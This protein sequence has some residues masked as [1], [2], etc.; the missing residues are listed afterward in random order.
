V[1]PRVIVEADAFRDA[2]EEVTG[3]TR[4]GQPFLVGLGTPTGAADLW[5]AVPRVAAGS[6]PAVAD[7]L[8]CGDPSTQEVVGARG[9]GALTRYCGSPRPAPG[10]RLDP[11]GED[12][13]F[14]VLVIVPLASGEVRID[15]VDVTHRS[16]WRDVTE[17]TGPRVVVR[18]R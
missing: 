4:V 7:V 11:D 1:A 17:H 12:D 3:R 2:G 5:A 13:P 10:A 15:G 8:V 9:V 18:V 16:G 6:A 14:L